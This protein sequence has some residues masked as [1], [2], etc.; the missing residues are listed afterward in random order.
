MSSP[1]LNAMKNSP[2]HAS[3]KMLRSLGLL[4]QALF[5]V[6]GA[7]AAQPAPLGPPPGAVIAASPDPQKKF[8]FS[9]SL[10]VLPDGNYVASYDTGEDRRVTRSALR[11]SCV[12][13]IFS[14]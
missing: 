3:L 14:S 7:M 1:A 8:V 9:P 13:L 5:P 11:F 2:I 4:F 10:A 12:T 6:C